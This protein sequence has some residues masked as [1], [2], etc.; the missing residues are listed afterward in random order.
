MYVPQTQGFVTLFTVQG[1]VNTPNFLSPRPQSSKG[2][3]QSPPQR[4]MHLLA[5]CRATASQFIELPPPPPPPVQLCRTHTSLNPS[6]SGFPSPTAV[7]GN[8]VTVHH[9][10]KKKDTD[11]AATP[12]EFGEVSKSGQYG[13]W[14]KI[15]SRDVVTVSGAMC[16]V[17]WYCVWESSIVVYFL[18]GVR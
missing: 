14:L 18:I 3:M 4:N 17:L 7:K 10:Q 5:W 16:Y 12:E 8:M 6:T 13:S 15:G 2:H 11:R 9:L 1:K